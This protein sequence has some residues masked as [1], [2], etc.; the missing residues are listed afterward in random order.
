MLDYAARS[1][2]SRD[3]DACSLRF[4][5]SC[6]HPRR[7]FAQGH[8]FTNGQTQTNH[9]FIHGPLTLGHINVY[10]SPINCNLG[11]NRRRFLCSVSPRSS[12]AE[13]SGS[14]ENPSAFES[15]EEFSGLRSSIRG[16]NEGDG[17][18]APVLTT[19][20][21]LK[22]KRELEKEEIAGVGSMGEELRTEGLEETTSGSEKE[23]IVA[24]SSGVRGVRRVMRRSNLLAK[25]V[26]SMESA[27]RLGF[28]SQLWVDTRSVSF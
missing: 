16:E 3:F 19:F 15:F 28:V 13:T 12:S 11:L 1:S 25:Q 17:N 22:L 27:R 2:L 7:G 23:G 8:L 10:N 18:G 4:A 9:S 5:P 14:D 26:I 24:G 21:F 20:D 6:P